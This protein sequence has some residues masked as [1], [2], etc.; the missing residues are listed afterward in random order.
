MIKLLW[1]R[2]LHSTRLNTQSQPPDLIRE[3]PGSNLG[4]ET[5]YSDEGFSRLIQHLQED[6][7][8]G[9]DTY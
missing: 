5:G 9:R 8:L 3:V 1:Y 2:F 7:R 6:S 4:P